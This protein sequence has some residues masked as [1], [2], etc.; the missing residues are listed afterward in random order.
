[1]GRVLTPF[2]V[3]LVLDLRRINKVRDYADLGSEERSTHEVGEVVVRVVF[4][5]SIAHLFPNRVG[6]DEINNC[7]YAETELNVARAEFLTYG[8]TAGQPSQTVTR[9]RHHVPKALTL[10]SI[11]RETQTSTPTMRSFFT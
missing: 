4:A 10:T 9:V 6:L 1:V 7:V 3:I 11:S 2:A 5:E 8:T